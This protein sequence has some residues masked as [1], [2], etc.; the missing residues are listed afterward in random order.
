MLLVHLSDVTH[1]V[2]EQSTPELFILAP[3]QAKEERQNLVGMD[4]ST[5]SQ[6]HEC[7]NQHEQ[8]PPEHLSRSSCTRAT[9][10]LGRGPVH[11]SVYSRRTASTRRVTAR[12]YS[13]A[14]AVRSL[15]GNPRG[16]SCTTLEAPVAVT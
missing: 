2:F 10:E 8:V 3:E 9:L 5:T 15:P 11:Q 14:T 7:I 1:D 4:C 13:G 12:P 6:Q 16:P